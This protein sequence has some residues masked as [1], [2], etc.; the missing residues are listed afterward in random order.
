MGMLIVI[1]VFLYDGIMT[2]YPWR[3]KLLIA[4]VAG[5]I[6][7]VFMISNN[8]I[9]WLIVHAT[10]NPQTGFWRIGTW[11]HAVPIIQQSPLL[12]HGMNSLVQ[13]GNAQLFL[14]SIDCLYLVEALRYG[15]PAVVLLLLTMLWPFLTKTGSTTNPKINHFRSGI[16]VAIISMGLIGI[17]V[18]FWDSLWLLLNLLMGIRASLAEYDAQKKTSPFTLGTASAANSTLAKAH[19]ANP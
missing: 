14:H 19:R 9:A 16:S 11:N 5:F 17:T 12:G 10:L 4:T 3:W 2:Q 1:A 8:P 7:I 15:I 6:S 13:S 18:H